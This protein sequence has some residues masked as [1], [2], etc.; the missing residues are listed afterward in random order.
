MPGLT[1]HPAEHL[2]GQN[3]A[4]FLPRQVLQHVPGQYFGYFFPQRVLGGEYK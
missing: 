4:V 3:I 2:P 1:G